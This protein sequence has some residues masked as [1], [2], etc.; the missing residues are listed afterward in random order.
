LSHFFVDRATPFRRSLCTQ[1]VNQ[2]YHV[3]AIDYRGY[4]DSTGEP[5]EAGV[6]KDVIALYDLLRKYRPA[7]Q[8]SSNSAQ[9][10]SVGGVYLFGHS[11]GTG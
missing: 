1:L 3:F 8:G 7:A 11:L 2:G 4:G 5:S 10:A 9:T 6:V